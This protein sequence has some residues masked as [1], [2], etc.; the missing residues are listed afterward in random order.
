MEGDVYVHRLAEHI[1]QYERRAKTRQ[2]NARAPSHGSTVVSYLTLGAVAAAPPV[3]TN[4]D[5]VPPLKLDPHHLMYLLL[6]L[7]GCDSLPGIE[8]LDRPWETTP[9]RMLNYYGTEA[10]QRAS[11]QSDKMS[12]ASGLSSYTFGS[13]WFGRD[14]EKTG[15][16]ALD[17][18]LKYL[19]A[20]CTVLP[21]LDMAPFGSSPS[22]RVIT[23]FETLPDELCVPLGLFKNLQRLTI[24]DLDPRAF[25]GW[26]R[27]ADTLV[28][29]SL[30]STGLEDISDLFI[31]KVLSDQ[32]SA[33]VSSQRQQAVERERRSSA[34]PSE[35]TPLLVPP[36]RLKQTAWS[37][38]RYLSL[39][40][41]YLTFVPMDLAHLAS[42]RHLDLSDNL[43]V[44]VPDGLADMFC[45]QT[46]NLSGNMI[47][48][49]LG[50]ARIL[51]NVTTVNL[52][53]NRLD[54]LC[55]LERLLALERL[56]LR[57][58][59]IQ[60]SS[61]VGRLA[62][63]PNLVELWVDNN[64]LVRTEA[65][66]RL[67]CFETFARESRTGGALTLK[68][69]GAAPSFTDRQALRQIRPSR[70]GQYATSPPQTA[71]TIDMAV[72]PMQANS[73]GKQR[74]RPPRIVRL[75]SIGPTS[76]TRT[77]PVHS[78]LEPTAKKV[79]P[80]RANNKTAR[81]AVAVNEQQGE[82][83]EALRQR[84]EALKLELGD[85]W[86]NVMGDEE[87]VPS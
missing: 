13:S 82:G 64:P 45:L 6:R 24:R 61:E 87:M 42:I 67:R 78:A 58:N 73:L 22:H 76:P 16:Q 63:L 19:Y 72:S 27:L 26:H 7:D 34:L 10:Q 47:D 40:S 41:N 11:D 25:A 44:A 71:S 83:P 23:S 30:I 14:S 5:D 43:L 81:A 59:G 36:A 74:R 28:Q 77:A 8:D 32:H 31:G 1:K 18:D 2:A 37:S 29:L 33:N 38:L 80:R 12:M 35:P 4:R 75:E 15:K 55:G 51:G 84:I 49:L 85:Q 50:I 48:S 53:N 17:A 21:A 62:P 79:A 52:A 70:P 20:A 57:S 56:D 66:W 69:D 60:D 46:L 39:A 68:L 86:L 54:S 3:R 9:S 65:D